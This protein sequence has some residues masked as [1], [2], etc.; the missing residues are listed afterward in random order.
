MTAVDVVLI[1]DLLGRDPDAA[2]IGAA[3]HAE[4]DADLAALAEN[5]VAGQGENDWWMGLLRA[6]AKA[7][8]EVAALGHDDLCSYGPGICECS[9]GETVRIMAPTVRAYLAGA[10]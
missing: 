2:L 10:R 3:E 4:Q 6:W 7:W 8:R 1:L 9:R 5:P